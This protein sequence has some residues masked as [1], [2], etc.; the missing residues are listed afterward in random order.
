MALF[1]KLCWTIAVV[2]L[3][4]LALGAYIATRTIAPIETRKPYI[5]RVPPKNYE[6]GI[7]R[8]APRWNWVICPVFG[9]CWKDGKPISGALG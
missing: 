8:T 6:P 4:P 9:P 1:L 2:S 3:F 7:E 5:E